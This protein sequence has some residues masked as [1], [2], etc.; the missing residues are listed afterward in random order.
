LYS[1]WHSSCTTSNKEEIGVINNIT[2][3][4]ETGSGQVGLKVHDISSL[5][6]IGDLK[7]YQSLYTT[8]CVFTFC[9]EFLTGQQIS[10]HNDIRVCDINYNFR[11]LPEQIHPG[12]ETGWDIFTLRIYANPVYHTSFPRLPFHRRLPKT[13]F[14]LNFDH[15]KEFGKFT[16]SYMII[17]SDGEISHTNVVSVDI[18]RVYL[19]LQFECIP[20]SVLLGQTMEVQVTLKNTLDSSYDGN[21]TFEWFTHNVTLNMEK[22]SS[23]VKIGPNSV[24]NILFKVTSTQIGELHFRVMSE[25][26]ERVLQTSSTKVIPYG[27]IRTLSKSFLIGAD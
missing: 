20:Y 13:S 9:E 15:F 17:N 14:T 8:I 25:E 27:T 21:I 12:N 16:I 5:Q 23:H 26:Y 4:R 1:T 6:R 22:L 7:S 11:Q 10:A 19:G 18:P 24:K 2:L 3:N